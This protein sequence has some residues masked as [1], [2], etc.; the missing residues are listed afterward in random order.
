MVRDTGALAEFVTRV[1]S[2][3]ARPVGCGSTAPQIDTNQTRS[4]QDG[5]VCRDPAHAAGQS[6]SFASPKASNQRKGDPDDC[7]RPSPG[8]A[9]T[10]SREGRGD[11]AALRA[12]RAIAAIISPCLLPS[13]AFVF[14]ISLACF[15][16]RHA[17][18]CWLSGVRRSSRLNRPRGTTP[19]AL[20]SLPMRRKIR[21][22]PST[23][24]LIAVNR[25]SVWI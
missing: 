16:A 4:S 5:F 22:H 2:P 17:R 12:P 25:L 21:L 14:S 18:A 11:Y 13:P 9:L 7:P 8:Q 15:P 20:G 10:L 1:P 19:I 6:L 23:P 3:L 24:S